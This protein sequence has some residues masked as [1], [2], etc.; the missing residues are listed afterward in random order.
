MILRNCFIYLSC[1]A[2][3]LLISTVSC[4]K[5]WPIPDLEIVSPAESS[6]VRPGER[7]DVQINFSSEEDEVDLTMGL[8]DDNLLPIG[9]KQFWTTTGAESKRSILIPIREY[10]SN[11][12]FVKVEIDDRREVNTRYLRLNLLEEELDVEGFIFHSK[13]GQ[14]HE[15][16]VESAAGETILSLNFNDQQLACE[17]VND[18]LL[19]IG[20]NNIGIRCYSL[21]TAQLVWSYPLEE[22]IMCWTISQKKLWMVERGFGIK[23]FDC[24]SGSEYSRIPLS[25]PEFQKRIAISGEH[26]ILLE[27]YSGFQDRLNLYFSETGFSFQDY[28]VNMKFEEIWI[29]EFDEVLLGRWNNKDLHFYEY[30]KSTNDIDDLNEAARS[31]ID[32]KDFRVKQNYEWLFILR[33]DQLRDE[34]KLWMSRGRSGQVESFVKND[35]LSFHPSLS[36]PFFTTQDNSGSSVRISLEFGVP[37][38]DAFILKTEKTKTYYDVLSY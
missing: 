36:A 38:G 12:I 21:A 18:H 2:L 15:I 16:E 24:Y 31:F 14:N 30:R 22:E 25:R 34:D 11:T 5:E 33:Y 17:V 20:Q 6:S 3:I 26:V 37:N 28:L 8:V 9:P 7:I 1:S 27:D 10:V 19:I 32:V 13:S 35:V 29:G 23:S 4:N